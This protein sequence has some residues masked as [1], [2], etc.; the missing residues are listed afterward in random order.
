MAKKSCKVYYW[1]LHVPSFVNVNSLLIPKIFLLGII[2]KETIQFITF[3][4]SKLDLCK[5]VPDTKTSF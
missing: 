2:L 4:I 3:L 1:N 5:A